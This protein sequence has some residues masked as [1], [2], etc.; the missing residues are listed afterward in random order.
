MV[1]RTLDCQTIVFPQIYGRTP[2]TYTDYNELSMFVNCFIVTWITGELNTYVIN[3]Q[4]HS[5]SG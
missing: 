4:M 3:H 5:V 2:M 1:D